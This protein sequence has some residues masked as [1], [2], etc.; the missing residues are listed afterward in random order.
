MDLH[1]IVYQVGDV[2]VDGY[3]SGTCNG[4]DV[5]TVL[6]VWDAI[7]DGLELEVQPMPVEPPPFEERPTT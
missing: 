3:V 4:L 5:V 2:T 6:E 1:D 7:T